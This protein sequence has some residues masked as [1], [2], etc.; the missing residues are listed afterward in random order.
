MSLKKISLLAVSIIAL[1]STNAFASSKSSQKDFPTK[2]DQ[3]L[4]IFMRPS[5]LGAAI[6]SPIL[7]ITDEQSQVIGNFAAGKK[8][9][10]YCEPGER[11]FMS[12]GE[13]VD[14]VDAK[15][16]AGK[17]YYVQII[18]KMGALKARFILKPFKKNSGD[19]DFAL[20]SEKQQKSFKKCK[21]VVTDDK[22]RKWAKNKS[23]KI[24]KRRSKFTEKWNAMEE[25][26]REWLSISKSDG[27]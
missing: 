2:E 10:Y 18:P 12:M 15:L 5:M 11:R 1:L 24:V 22:D 21:W 27:V 23:D 20:N 8:I 17:I 6:K 9:A 25:G 13:N 7:D 3:A 26:E 16:A 14:F 4:V 19:P